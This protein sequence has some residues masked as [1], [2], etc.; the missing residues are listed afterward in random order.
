MEVAESDCKRSMSEAERTGLV[1]VKASYS[2]AWGQCVE[3]AS[4]PGNAVAMRDSKD[5]DGPILFYSRSEFK[6]FLDGALKGDF[7]AIGQ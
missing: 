6:A 5:P 2:S 7:D 1:W 3:I 4:A